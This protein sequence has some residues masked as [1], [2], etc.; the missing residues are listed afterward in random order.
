MFNLDQ[1]ITEWRRQMAAGGLRTPAVLDELESH[2]RE[3]VERQTRV[4]INEA[5]AF[6]TA[7]KNIGAAKVLKSEF[8]KSTFAGVREKLMIAV[9]ALFVAFGIFLTSVTLILCYGSLGERL[10]GFTALGFMLLAGLGWP[11][12][13]PFLP[14]IV[15]KGK[16]WMAEVA[17]L[18]VGFGVAT[19]YVQVIVQHFDTRHEGLPAIGFWAVFPI[20]IGFGLA[21]GLERA[22][23]EGTER[24]TA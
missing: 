23:Q 11:Y 18:L 8:K 5:R 19:F 2:L 16:R 22:A 20:A 7:V 4:G 24:I 14:V 21:C 3:D 13:A 17:C 12:V 10:A 9:A 6:E 1:A 15:S